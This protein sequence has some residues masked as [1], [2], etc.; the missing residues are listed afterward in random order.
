MDELTNR[1]SRFG[2]LVRQSA[3]VENN[4]NSVERIVYYGQKIEQEAAHEAP[5]AK[6]QAPWPAGGRV[7]LKNI[8][9]NYRPGL[10]AVLKGISMDV[11][12]GEKIGVIGRFVV[13]LFASASELK[14]Q[15]Q[16]RCRKEFNHD[17]Y[18]IERIRDN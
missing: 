15:L 17:R 8:F 10:P 11:G 13:A 4:M 2:F 12:A 9:L 18:V 7:E 6:P 5:E 1:E 14:R 16:D 3:E